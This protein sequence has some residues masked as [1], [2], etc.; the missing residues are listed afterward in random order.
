MPSNIVLQKTYSL[1]TPRLGIA[2]ELRSQRNIDLVLSDNYDFKHCDPVLTVEFYM[3]WY[4][5]FLVTWD[6][7]EP[8]ISEKTDLFRIYSI[9]FGHLDDMTPRPEGKEA[10]PAYRDHVPNPLYVRLFANRHNFHLDSLAEE[11][12]V[13]RW[14]MECVEWNVMQCDRCEGAGVIPKPGDPSNI[15]PATCRSCKGHGVLKPGA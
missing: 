14:Q 1:I 5:L 6:P 11:L 13:G 9:H 2:G 15:V 3:K 7:H 8:E 10:G 4:E 12:I